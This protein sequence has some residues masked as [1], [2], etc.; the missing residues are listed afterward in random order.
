MY[1]F[2]VLGLIP[3]TSIQITFLDW[4]DMILICIELL[5]LQWLI[6]RHPILAKKRFS[7]ITYIT[8][9]WIIELHAQFQSL[10]HRTASAE[11]KP[12]I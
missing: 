2:I 1:S 7:R 9:D 4:I 10:L 12:S 11:E 6:Q 5:A 3:E 8:I